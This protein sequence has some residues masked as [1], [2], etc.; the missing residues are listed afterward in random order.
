MW[1]QLQL[2]MTKY[3]WYNHSVYLRDNGLLIGYLETP[4]WAYAARIRN[5]PINQRWQL[6]L[7]DYFEPLDD[8]R[9]DKQGESL[10]TL[11]QI[12]YHTNKHKEAEGPLKRIC[13]LLSLKIPCVSTYK[14][15]HENV[16]PEV[17]EAF[18]T[19]G[20]RNYSQFMRDDGLIIGYVECA[21][22]EQSLAKL[23]NEPIVK[24]WYAELEVFMERRP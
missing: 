24:K 3:G 11:E 23:E 17:L 10:S 16:W 6:A 7:R 15:K 8:G 20:W 19:H 4:D 1:P 21:D 14:A 9:F 2:A 12:F 13:F 5:E 22:W 18:D